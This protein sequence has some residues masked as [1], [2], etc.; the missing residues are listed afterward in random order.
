MV[1]IIPVRVVSYF[2]FVL[3][4]CITS[5]KLPKMSSLVACSL[6]RAF[7]H[8]QMDPPSLNPKHLYSRKHLAILKDLSP[9]MATSELYY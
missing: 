9:A 3:M 2:G 7:I 4:R 1:G 8:S 5:R 6:S